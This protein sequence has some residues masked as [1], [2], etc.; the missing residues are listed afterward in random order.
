MPKTKDGLGN[1]LVADELYYLQ[2]ARQFVGVSILWWCHDAC[3]YT[4][5]MSRAGTF[6]G[7]ACATVISDHHVP[8]PKG[9]VEAHI[10]THVRSDGGAF[11]CG[12]KAHRDYHEETKRAHRK[13]MRELRRSRL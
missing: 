1:P 8:W 12:N 4:V 10:T 11:E 3:G 13:H 5:E 9:Y 7:E 2:D 6:S